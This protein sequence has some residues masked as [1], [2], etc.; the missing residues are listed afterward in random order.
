MENQEGE[1]EYYVVISQGKE[2]Y[3]AYKCLLL[4]NENEGVLDIITDVHKYFDIDGTETIPVEFEKI[5]FKERN[6]MSVPTFLEYSNEENRI[7][8]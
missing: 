1:K 8:N 5:N 6:A 3:S 2:R 4:C 7:D